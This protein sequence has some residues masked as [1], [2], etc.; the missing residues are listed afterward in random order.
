MQDKKLL[1]SWQTVTI[2]FLCRSTFKY[3]WFHFKHVVHVD[4][5]RL[6]LWTAATNKPIVNSSDYDII[7]W[8]VTVEWYWQGRTEKL[9]E[10]HVPVPLC[11]PQIPHEL[12]RV[13]TQTSVVRGQQLTAWGM[14]GPTK[15]VGAVA[16]NLNQFLRVHASNLSHECV[17]LCDV[18]KCA[19]TASS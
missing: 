5:V 10:R 4:V 8:R 1:W 7:A 2:R 16:M 19:T 9:G 18:L 11:P 12:I 3:S 13:R 15:H 17:V 6:C 14:A